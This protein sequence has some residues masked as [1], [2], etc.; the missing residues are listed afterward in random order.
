M[1]KNEKLNH[2]FEHAD[3][4]LNNLKAL[5]NDDFE[6]QYNLVNKLNKSQLDIYVEDLILTD[7]FLVANENEKGVKNDR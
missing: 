1:T 6:N 4:L 7:G 2:C 3:K 5:I